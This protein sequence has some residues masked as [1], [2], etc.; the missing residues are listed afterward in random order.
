[1]PQLRRLARDQTGAASI[2]LVS[3]DMFSA[4][5][6]ITLAYAISHT[7]DH[8]FILCSILCTLAN[9]AVFLMASIRRMQFVHRR[10]IVAHHLYY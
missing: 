9:L 1:M 2:S 7:G 4:C 8:L 5:N 6:A 10:A 3:W